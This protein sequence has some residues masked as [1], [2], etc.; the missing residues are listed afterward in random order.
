[1]KLISLSKFGTAQS[2]TSKEQAPT[3][4]Q[5]AHE[6]ECIPVDLT[7]LV[8]LRKLHEH[9]LHTFNAKKARYEEKQDLLFDEPPPCKGELDQVIARNSR[10]AL[11]REVTKEEEELERFG[12]YFEAAKLLL[13]RYGKFVRNTSRAVG[14]QD[15]SI[16]PAH[17]KEFSILVIEFV[18]LAMNFTTSIKIVSR[19]TSSSQCE[20]GGVI[21]TVN[22]MAQCSS[23]QVIMK[24][25]EAG[26]SQASGGSE[27]C[28]TEV[29]A[30]TL[31]EIQGKRKK[32]IA[33]EVYEII[34]HFCDSRSIDVGA[35]SRKEVM[36]I[37][38][39]AKLNEYYKSINLIMHV[40]QGSP[41]P[42]FENLREALIG[43]HRLIEQEYFQ[44]RTDEGRDNFLR[45]QFVARACLQMEKYPINPDHF[46]Q[47]STPEAQYD[48]NRIMKI[49]CERIKEKQKT[50]AS[51]RGS[52]DFEPIQD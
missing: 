14:E 52:W 7:A 29:F 27:Y 43:R 44:I 48:H 32:A 33:P 18:K 37:L 31:D 47:L 1:M 10:A 8:D 9:V 24:T 4:Y 41:L 42:N 51:I 12:E 19:S 40:L 17:E 21:S 3:K 6:V 15:K 25:K 16:D 2:S 50:D 20:C 38:K 22:G 26:L 35:L 5:A 45:T 13:E 39:R 30:E 36:E 23:C 49:I 34:H 46:T 28:R 11:L